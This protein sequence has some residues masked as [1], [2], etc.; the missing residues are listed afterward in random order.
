[1]SAGSQRKGLSLIWDRWHLR[2]S[3]DDPV[4]ISRR[5][6]KCQTSQTR[7]SSRDRVFI[8][9]QRIAIQATQI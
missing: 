4:E 1:M 6:Q 8:S 9:D 2:P 5:P 3:L 7:M